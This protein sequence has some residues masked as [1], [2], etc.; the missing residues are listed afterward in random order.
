MAGTVSIVQGPKEPPLFNKTLGQIIDEQDILHSSKTFIHSTH[1]NRQVSYAELARRSRILARSMLRAG[2]QWGDHLGLFLPNNV[3]HCELFMAAGRIG[4]PVVS[5][6][7][8]FTP[9]ELAAAARFTDCKAVFICSEIEKRSL[10]DHIKQLLSVSDL[11]VVQIGGA[12]RPG[13]QLQSYSQF[14]LSDSND[15]ETDLREVERRVQP[16]S[17]LNI[18]FTSG[19][20]GAPKAAMLTHFGNVNMAA[21]C[22]RFITSS[23]SSDRLLVCTPLFHCMGSI[24][25][26]LNAF[27]A[28]SSVVFAS[29]LFD[30]SSALAALIAADVTIMIG[31]PTMFLAVSE[32]AKSQHASNKITS[33]RTGF[34]AGAA[35]SPEILATMK[36]ALG[37]TP[38]IGYGITEVSMGVTAAGPTASDEKKTSTCGTVLPHI[39]VRVV[40]PKNPTRILPSGQRGELLIS[41]FGLLQG[42]Y[43]KPEKTAE[44]VIKD[45]DGTKWLRSGDEAKIDGDG[46]VVITGR[47]KDIIIRAGENIYPAEIEQR[48]LSH[49]SVAE[50]C[51]IGVPDAKYGEAV[52]AFLRPELS[53]AR[54]AGDEEIR[55]WV[56][57][58]LAWQKAPKHVFWLGE[59]G[60]PAEY[61]KTGSGKHQK[62]VLR[63]MASMILAA[64]S[65]EG[66]AKL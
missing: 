29:P 3:E 37:L 60:L 12:I 2:L 4:L 45:A 11:K 63:E 39:S 51:V 33:L 25:G 14:E 13:L 61:P 16:T 54:H 41:S 32:L 28:G 5:F 38:A 48:L 34:I 58:T 8:T 42:Y 15:N 52:A 27:L 64:E 40:D 19:T 17:I 26:L 57:E 22:S 21:H 35:C 53:A 62:H 9:Q 23:T 20:T 56:R 24:G 59:K 18:Q 47:I 49:P 50:A 66:K 44:A 65:R 46:Y 6:N 30:A 1:Q 36:K 43:K 10:S 55:M 31:V 7:L